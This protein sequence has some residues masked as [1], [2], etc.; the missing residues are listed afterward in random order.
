M[1][2]QTIR[3][4]QAKASK[5]Q[6]QWTKKLKTWA[7]KNFNRY[8]EVGAAFG[9]GVLS[10][11]V[12]FGM[13]KDGTSITQ[14]EEEYNPNDNS[15][16]SST[17][18]FIQE[19]EENLTQNGA[20]AQS[21]TDEMSFAEA[22]KTS[23]EELGAGNFFRWRDRLYNNYTESEFEALSEEQHTALV[24]NISNLAAPSDENF[25]DE[26]LA[27]N[28]SAEEPV[29]SAP[30]SKINPN[31]NTNT[32]NMD[33]L[34]ST[35]QKYEYVDKDGDGQEDGALINMDNDPEAEMIFDWS[36]AANPYAFV[37]NGN[38]GYLNTVYSIDGEGNLTNPV[39][40]SEGIPG[41]KLTTEQ[42]MDLIGDDG[43]LESKA[44]DFKGDSRADRVDVDLS[45]DG[46][47]DFAYCDTTGDGLLDT[48]YNIEGGKLTE[49]TS[50]DPFD[51]PIVGMV[52]DP[53]INNA[54]NTGQNQGIANTPFEDIDMDEEIEGMQ[55]D[56]DPDM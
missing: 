12:F 51:S 32:Q 30:I 21:V 22:F 2:D 34:A 33:T 7:D 16:G 53:Q 18:D 38:T 14:S 40:L 24:D 42:L 35:T 10:Y 36:D 31:F 48:V 41:P 4:N 27:P 47:Y 43:I 26:N 50:I 3:V 37:D 39:P 11:N 17:Y 46:N 8:A 56:I 6:E 55:N 15:T 19:V 54:P 49:G 23:R 45:G 25:S 9:T 13:R 44:Y 29:A 20:V 1:S 28:D 5:T 52:T